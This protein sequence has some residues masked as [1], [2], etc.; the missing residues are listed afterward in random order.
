MDYG[1]ANRK[2]LLLKIDRTRTHYQ[3]QNNRVRQVRNIIVKNR[4]SR[5]YEGSRANG[6]D[7]D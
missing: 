5:K 3:I 6:S 1:D 7:L 2:A 4:P